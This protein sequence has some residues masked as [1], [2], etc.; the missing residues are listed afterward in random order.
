MHKRLLAF[1]SG[2]HLSV[3][4][5]NPGSGLEMSH[6]DSKQQMGFPVMSLEF[7]NKATAHWYDMNSCGW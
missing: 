4:S 1:E 3:F 7:S 6:D 2:L 5:A